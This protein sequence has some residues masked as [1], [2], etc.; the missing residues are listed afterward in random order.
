MMR[1][2]AIILYKFATIVLQ[3]LYLKFLTNMLDLEQIARYSLI[4]SFVAFFSSILYNPIDSY[5]Q[6]MYKT[7]KSFIQ[8]QSIIS[9]I[10]NFSPFI[11]IVKA[12]VI[13]GVVFF[14]NFQSSILFSVLLSFFIFISSCMLRLF[15]NNNYIAHYNNSILF[16]WISKIII[17]C[18]FLWAATEVYILF[19]ALISAQILSCFFAYRKFKLVHSEADFYHLT[20]GFRGVI[21]NLHDILKYSLPLSAAGLVVWIQLNYYR[22]TINEYSSSQ[23]ALF[24]ILY[25]IGA[26]GGSII[27]NLFQQKFISQLMSQRDRYLIKYLLLSSTIFGLFITFC[28]FMRDG[29]VIMLSGPNFLNHSY[30][31]IYGIM[32][33]FLFMC[34]GAVEICLNF[35]RLNK[36]ILLS[37]FFGLIFMFCLYYYSISDFE[38]V[39]VIG[40]SLMGSSLLTFMFLYIINYIARVKECI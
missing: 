37:H 11:L 27:A 40:L 1:F 16:E 20:F 4:L 5:I 19:M 21:V 34:I 33:E 22:I 26:A 8:F 10:F 39:N 2:K 6:I 24:F 14:L 28:Y 12:L 36:T 18:L 13:G 29:I 38:F 30:L 23:V 9:F 3:V 25:S 31:I 15:I 35:K 17:T 7:K 32:M